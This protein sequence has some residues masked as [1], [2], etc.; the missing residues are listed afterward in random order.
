LESCIADALA[1]AEAKYQGRIELVAIERSA[2]I[3]FFGV[4]IAIEI[5]ID[6]AIAGKGTLHIAETEAER[7]AAL[8][9]NGPKIPS[10]PTNLSVELSVRNSVV[11]LS[12]GELRSLSVG[13]VLLTDDRTAHRDYIA[14]TLGEIWLFHAQFTPDGLKQI[15]PLRR[16][17]AKD[18][19]LWMMVDSMQ[20]TDGEDELSEAFDQARKVEATGAS[21][22]AEASATDD[23]GDVATGEQPEE[24][25]FD[26]LP[27][28]LVFELGRL[29]MTLGRLQEV[30]PGHIFELGRSV[31]EAVQVYAGGRRIGQ[32]DIVKI[33]D[34]IGVR[35]ARLFGDV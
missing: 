32:G 34:Q 1:T 31:G 19:E 7:I 3:D 27:I 12:L 28:K 14:V 8:F 10:N 20:D 11:W 2:A 9:V 13:D 23:D 33:D 17:A 29:E 22:D 5:A 4:Q 26:E 30:G 21:T 24:S 15:E 35:M 16:A 6:G 25:T 18:R